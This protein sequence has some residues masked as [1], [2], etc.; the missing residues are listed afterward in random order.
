MVSISTVEATPSSK[1][2]VLY[3]Q[4]VFRIARNWARVPGANWDKVKDPLFTQCPHALQ[5]E[6]MQND[7]SKIHMSTN[8]RL[9]IIGL[10]LYFLESKGCHAGQIVPYMLW[11][12]EKLLD[13]DFTERQSGRF[14][15]FAY[16]P[17]YIL[18]CKDAEH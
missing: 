11:I 3:R 2:E 18:K 12:E 14:S 5:Y 1:P 8:N 7:E 10:G 6:N 15:K 17:R 16:L 13:M 4:T 9:S